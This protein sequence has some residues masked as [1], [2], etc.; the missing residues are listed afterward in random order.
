VRESLLE[1][2]SNSLSKMFRFGKKKE[3]RYRTHPTDLL[4]AFFILLG[5]SSSSLVIF[6]ENI[7]LGI[8]L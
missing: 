1:S 3:N 7:R 5:I 2:N 8:T 4:Y 6:V